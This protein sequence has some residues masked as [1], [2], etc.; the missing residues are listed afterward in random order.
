MSGLMD[1]GVENAPIGTARLRI[2]IG[3]GHELFIHA[4]HDTD[5]YTDVTVQWVV[6]AHIT[7]PIEQVRDRKK[8]ILVR[9][10]LDHRTAE[11]LPDQTSAFDLQ[12]HG[13]PS[14]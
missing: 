7:G 8:R 3:G 1:V 4:Q 11:V 9:S 14:A 10:K 2:D 5:R 6:P 12:S 13:R